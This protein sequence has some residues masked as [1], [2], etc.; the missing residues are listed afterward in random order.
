MTM[1]SFITLAIASLLAA[2]CEGKPK[3]S[4]LCPSG[5]LDK[6]T[7][8]NG[9]LN[10][11]NARRA[12][13]AQGTQKNGRDGFP[14]TLPPATNMTQLSWGC[15]LEQD[16]IKALGNNCQ[17]PGNPNPPNS[18]GLANIFDAQYQAPGQYGMA[19][20]KIFKTYLKNYLQQID[21]KHLDVHTR[22]TVLSNAIYNG[23]D[24]DFTGYAELVRATNMEIGCAMI[25]CT[26][27]DLITF[28]CVM[29]GKSIQK[30]DA[31]YKGTTKNVGRC[32]EV[33]CPTGY[34]CNDTTLL[35]VKA[36]A[37]KI[38]TG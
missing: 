19:A 29:N 25:R 30:G 28:Y 1:L 16:A 23:G 18:G 9:I 5:Y 15:Q 10:P 36:T 2:L 24:K 27:P 3:L 17:D 26:A 11:V 31:V 12:K 38:P 35:C 33:I 7:I 21:V 14:A 37:K 6:D 22:G 34:T 8:D 32:K 13:L 20:M 4:P